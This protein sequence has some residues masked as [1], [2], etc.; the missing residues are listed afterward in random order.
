[1]IKLV[2]LF[3]SF[4]CVTVEAQD[5]GFAPSGG[6]KNQGTYNLGAEI[7]LGYPSVTI[8]NPDG[9][10][11]IYDGLAIRGI[12][13]IPLYRGKVFDCYLSPTAK[14]LD[15]E[16]IANS[17]A[18]FESANLAGIGGGLTF[19]YKR[20][21]F[22]AR[23]MQMWARHYSSGAFSD[24]INYQ[25]YELEYFGGVYFQFDRLGLGIVY[26]HASADVGKSSTGMEANTP[27]AESTFMLQGTF[28]MGASLWGIL[29][30][31]F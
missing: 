31:L 21:W 25:F 30:N 1:M 11:A 6:G 20:L 24:R 3:I 14:Y 27:Y 19:R 9:T 22:G 2:L 17:S 16:N 4:F 5:F 23:Y 7:Q 15:L 13:N 8:T 28:D 26:S 10:D 12:F 18:Q 29:S